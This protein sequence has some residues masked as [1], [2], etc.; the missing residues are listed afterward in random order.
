MKF[1]LLPLLWSKLKEP[2]VLKFFPISKLGE[3]TG[4][5]PIRANETDSG[6]DFKTPFDFTLQ[7][8]SSQKIPLGIGVDLPELPIIN[9]WVTVDMFL[10]PK[11]GLGL[12]G[13]MTTGGV[14]DNGYTGELMANLLNL[15]PEIL[16]FKRGDKVCQGVLRLVLIPRTDLTMESCVKVTSRG[17]KGFGSTGR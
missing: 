16:E 14:I 4:F 8:G 9:K 2:F 6:M 11:S 12:K 7:P 5:L 13:V 15:G 3:P 1:L 17:D 10:Q